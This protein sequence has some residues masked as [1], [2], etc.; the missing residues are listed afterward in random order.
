MKILAIANR[1]PARGKKGDQIISFERLIYLAKNNCTIELVC[2]GNAAEA[3]V[4]NSKME[5]E[6]YGIKVHLIKWS[7]LEAICN[8]LLATLNAKIP[9]QVALYKSRSFASQTKSLLKIFQPN[10]LY[11]VTIRPA[12]NVDLN[13][14]F[15]LDMVDSMGL[16]LSRR[17]TLQRGIKRWILSF[18]KIRVSAY[19]KLLANW[20]KHSFLVS[21]IDLKYIG[22]NTISALPLGVD[23][24]TFFRR[25][26]PSSTPTVI[27]TGNM[28]YQPN[29]DAIIWFVNNCWDQIRF[30]VP[31]AS[32]KVVGANPSQGVL[33][34]A[35][36]QRG[37]FV[38]GRVESVALEINSSHVSIAPM[39]SGSGMQFKILE[40]MACGV[41]VVAT[42]LGLGDIAAQPDFEIVLGDSANEFSEQVIKLI[43][44]PHICREIG[45]RAL[46]FIDLNHS[47]NAIN[48]QFLS[49]ITA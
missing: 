36:D 33:G 31:Y 15:I 26:T 4:I 37:I 44:S 34:L 1:I 40:A 18:E 6:G 16:N 35:S 46:R 43:Q 25:N 24:N 7:R 20:S 13:T 49:K 14:P 21:Q 29:I 5:L 3:E 38:T 9:F 10:Y 32:L 22:M 27:F 30:A 39:Q 2:F 28:N 19:E 8:L 47:W 42:R 41:P 48:H 12:L 17:L 23:R 11:L 45:V